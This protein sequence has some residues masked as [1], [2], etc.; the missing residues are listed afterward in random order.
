MG[1]YEGEHEVKEKEILS[2]DESV[3]GRK[4]EK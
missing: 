4:R 3:S 1:H 2:N